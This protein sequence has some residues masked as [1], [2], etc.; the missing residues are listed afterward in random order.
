MNHDHG[1]NASTPRFWRS[2][3]GVGLLVLGAIAAYFLLK[4][5]RAHMFGLLPFLL[6][7]ACPLMHLFMHHGHG[8]GDHGHSSHAPPPTPNPDIGGDARIR[9]QSGDQP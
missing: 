1:D 2:R 8:H 4:E 3:Y 7:A 6:F 5:H 9:D